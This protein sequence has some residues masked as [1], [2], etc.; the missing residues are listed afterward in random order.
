MVS[1]RGKRNGSLSYLIVGQLAYAKGDSFRTIAS[2]RL[3]VTLPAVCVLGKGA[4]YLE[5]R[6]C[7]SHVG[8]PHRQLL[9][10]LR[11]RQD[12]DDDD[13]DDDGLP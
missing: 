9:Q 10:C 12:D 3:V 8:W 7:F 6:G 11:S 2:L 1:A 5:K 4:T 13:D